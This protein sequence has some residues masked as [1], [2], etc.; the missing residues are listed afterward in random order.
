MCF[1][2][3]VKNTASLC[4]PPAVKGADFLCTLM[5]NYAP[6]AD[7]CQ[8]PEFSL[9]HTLSNLSIEK[10]KKFLEQIFPKMLDKLS[11]MW[12]YNIRKRDKGEKMMATKITMDPIKFNIIWNSIIENG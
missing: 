6:V 12:Y 10:C 3:M 1:S 9:Y 11:L 5:N 8:R 7:A 4:P 2:G